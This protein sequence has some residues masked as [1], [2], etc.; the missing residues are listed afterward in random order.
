MVRATR[1][2]TPRL[3]FRFGPR[4]LGSNRANF[5]RPASPWNVHHGWN[6]MKFVRDGPR[7]VL[8]ILGWYPRLVGN[9]R[10]GKRRRIFRGF[11]EEELGGGVKGWVKVWKFLSHRQRY[12]I[13][14][15][16]QPIAL[17]ARDLSKVI[18][19]K[20]ADWT[21]ASTHRIVGRASSLVRWR[22]TASSTSWLEEN[23]QARG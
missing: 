22:F 10:T 16:S 2:S 17:F 23:L 12:W 8:E 14:R 4:A 6:F 5:H 21:E 9:R 15:S 11:L 13:F 1:I 20:R 7:G 19:M 18:R 3:R